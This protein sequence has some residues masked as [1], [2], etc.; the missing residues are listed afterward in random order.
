MSIL[1]RPAEDSDIPYLYD[2][3][4]KTGD[5]GNDATGLFNDPLL[6]GQ[7]Y[8][9]PYLFYDKSLCFIAEEDLVPKGYVLAAD[10][11]TFNFWFGREWLP[12]LRRRYPADRS[13]KTCRSKFEEAMIQLV[14][15][16]VP[17]INPRNDPW[18]RKYPVHLHIDLL[19][20]L[21]GKGCGRK[22]MDTLG[23]ELHRRRCPG[24]H[25]GVS[26]NNTHAIGF[27]EKL[28]FSILRRES[29]GLIMGKAL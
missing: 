11:L 21:Q 6:L 17:F 26:G 28:G 22:L 3:C 15:S 19:P 24:I 7:Y 27:Y 4:L 25:L 8:A 10:T 9:A 1:I 16:T 13:G 18:I 14:H 20:D 29:W 5:S 12:S 23:E 2:I